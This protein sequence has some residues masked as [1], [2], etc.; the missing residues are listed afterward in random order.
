[1]CVFMFVGGGAQRRRGCSL[2]V[3]SPQCRLHHSHHSG[4]SG[5]D[6]R[7]LERLQSSAREVDC[8]YELRSSALH[9]LTK[10]NSKHKIDT[11]VK[12]LILLLEIT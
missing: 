10:L 7:C 8:V 9:T 4:A 11:T 12:R 2:A 6:N 5:E 3:I 1:M